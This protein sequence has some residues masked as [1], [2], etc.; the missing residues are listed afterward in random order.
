MKTNVKKHMYILPVMQLILVA[1]ALPLW[2]YVSP[3]PWVSWLIYFVGAML[4]I[5]V[6]WKASI[7]RN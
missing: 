1:V 3:P 6:L 2:V 7:I 5:I 4:F